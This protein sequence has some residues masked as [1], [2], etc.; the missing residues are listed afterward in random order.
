MT[1]VA[2]ETR[3]NY[4][5]AGSGPTRGDRS[6]PAVTRFATPIRVAFLAGHKSYPDEWVNFQVLRYKV[7]YWV[8]EFDALQA[9]QSENAQQTDDTSSARKVR[10]GP[11]VRQKRRK[12]LTP[13]VILLV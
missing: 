3:Q 11:Q 13:I 7:S 10:H 2:A 9:E 1:A 6:A 12:T 8:Q 5:F 4:P